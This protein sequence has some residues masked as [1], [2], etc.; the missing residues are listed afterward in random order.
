MTGATTISREER[1]RTVTSATGIFHGDRPIED[2]ERD[3]LVALVAALARR[4]ASAEDLAA[5]QSRYISAG[6]LRGETPAALPAG[7]LRIE[8]AVISLPA[9]LDG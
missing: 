4:L 3:Q 1:E 5:W 2:L 9:A 7:D 8:P 6:L